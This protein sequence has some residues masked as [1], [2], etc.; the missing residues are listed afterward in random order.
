MGPHTNSLFCLLSFLLLFLLLPFFTP[1]ERCF[2]AFCE[3]RIEE[4]GREETGVLGCDFSLWQ[5]LP[6]SFLPLLNG[7]GG[8]GGGGETHP[9]PPPPPPQTSQQCQ[10]KDRPL[11]FRLIFFPF[12][13]CKKRKLT[14]FL[15][16][17]HGSC[18]ML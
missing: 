5:F 7:G 1:L 15:L 16:G 2:L 13:L 8:G 14:R 12:T 6:P 17:L 11:F 4:A 3:G 10:K 18:M 9:H